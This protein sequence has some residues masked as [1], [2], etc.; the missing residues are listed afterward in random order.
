MLEISKRRFVAVDR[1]FDS[2]F[3]TGIEKF[4]PTERLLALGC[5]RLLATI[6]KL[7]MSLVRAR[8]CLGLLRRTPT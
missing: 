1:S 3:G 6:Q 2:S 5:S 7:R 8:Y 4:D